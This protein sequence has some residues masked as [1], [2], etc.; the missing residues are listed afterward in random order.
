MLELYDLDADP[1]EL[2]NVAGQA[3]FRDVQQT[4]MAALQEKLIT[5]YD[6]VPP[7]L[8]EALPRPN[9]P[10]KKAPQQ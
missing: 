9:A 3:E 7:V 5:D 1:S 2:H 10:A 6:Y 8:N 4:L